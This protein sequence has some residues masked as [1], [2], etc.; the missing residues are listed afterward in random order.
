MTTLE[1]GVQ[2]DPTPQAE[3]ETPAP[4]AGHVDVEAT[5]TDAAP[6]EPEPQPDDSPP[7]EYLDVEEIGGKFVKIKV[8][9]EEQELPLSDVLKG[10]NSNSAATK[11]FQEAAKI[12]E[13]AENALNLARAL[14]NDPGMTMQVLARQQGMTVEQ[15]LNLSPAQQEAAARQAEPEPEFNDPLEK[16]LYEERKA[17]ERLEARIEAAEQ[18]RARQEADN[19]LRSAISGLQTNFGATEE[20]ARNVVAQ[21]YQMGVGIEAF[22]MIYQAQQY[23]RMQAQTQARNEAQTSQQAQ[24]AARRQA[25]AEA[26][27]TVGTGTGAVGTAPQEVVR[28]LNAEEAIRAALEQYGIE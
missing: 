7:P 22:P 21:A 17:R 25:A 20:D 13:E 18:E 26:A 6:A 14:Q 15:F 19:Q 1:A 27:Q 4:D 9:G 12:R 11:R 2:A 5:P 23:Q 16:A 8:D 3:T 24:D 28:P 10:Y